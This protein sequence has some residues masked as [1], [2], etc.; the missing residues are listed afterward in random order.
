MGGD[1]RVGLLR[2]PRALVLLLAQMVVQTSAVL[3]ELYT[4]NA[5]CSQKYCINPVFPAV[6]QMPGMEATRWKKQRLADVSKFM[7][8]CGQVLDYDPAV[9]MLRD[10][11]ETLAERQRRLQNRSALG[12]PVTDF[13]TTAPLDS[14]KEAVA[15]FDRQA[16]TRYF[17]HLSG[18][19]VEAWD[20]AEPM[21]ASQHPLRLC[22]KS[23]ARLVCLTYFP[24]APARQAV[25]DD[26]QY[27]RPC[28]SSCENY[29]EACGVQCCDEGVM[30]V[31]G[32]AGANATD[33]A[34]SQ[35]KARPVRTMGPD[36][37]PILLQSGYV[38]HDAP[39]AFCSGGGGSVA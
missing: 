32:T 16:A 39:S 13:E 35:R 34:A 19:G 28:K 7:N 18:M 1:E 23:V 37:K 26:V 29:L 22:A 15:L 20:H 6:E 10:G 31:W 25:G 12:L 30:C 3:T 2:P 21:Q 14:L 36:G 33:D 9:P 38:D 4:T 17:V 8:F 24:E 27:L 11:N 5:M